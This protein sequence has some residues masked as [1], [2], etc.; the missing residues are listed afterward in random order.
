MKTFFI[1]ITS[2]NS[3]SGVDVD[4]AVSGVQPSPS[5]P[6]TSLYSLTPSSAMP[7]GLVAAVRPPGSKAFLFYYAKKC[8]AGFPQYDFMGL[9][10]EIFV[11]GISTQ[12]RPVWIGQLETK[13]KTSKIN[14]WIYRQIFFSDVSDSA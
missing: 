12:I 5:S 1:Q 4:V 11:A 8:N 13:P 6:L 10:H 2:K 3:A 7:S 14:G 9:K